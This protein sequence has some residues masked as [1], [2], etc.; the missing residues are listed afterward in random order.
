MMRRLRRRWQ[1]LHGLIYPIALLAVLHFW[2]M[3][4]SDYREPLVYGAI[5]AL[6]LGARL[7]RRY[8]R[9]RQVPAG[10]VATSMSAPPKAPERT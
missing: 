5:L 9:R 3:L 7:W 10:A 1:Q 6:L 8:R 2:K 4:K